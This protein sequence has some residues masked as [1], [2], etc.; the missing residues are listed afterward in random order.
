PLGAPRPVQPGPPEQPSQAPAAQSADAPQEAPP[1]A[2]EKTVRVTAEGYNRD[3]ALKQALRRA[4]EQGA[5]VQLTAHAQTE[6]Y[7][8]VRDTVYS[9]AAGLI[10]EYRVLKEEE[11]ARGN[12]EVTID[13]VVRP[14]VVAAAWGEIQMLLDQVGRPK[15]MVW[16]DETID[17]ELQSQSVVETSI[18]ELLT[19][20][21]FDIVARQGIE[22][23]RRRELAA[24]RAQRDPKNSGQAE[25]DAEKLARLAKDAGAHI[26]IRGTAN[27]NRAGVSTHYGI[28]A[29]YYN[30][31]AQ[32]K[33]YYTDTARVLASETSPSQRAGARSQQEYSPQAARA[34]LKLATLPGSPDDH[35]PTLATKL[36]DAVL[37]QWS[38]Q[39]SAGGDVELEVEG[40]DFRGFVDLKRALTE[41]E[42]V[43]SVD[44]DFTRGAGRYRIKTLMSAHTLAELLAEAPFTRPLEITDLKPNRI[45]ARPAGGAE[46]RPA[47]ESR[48]ASALRA[49]N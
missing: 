47:T 43:R 13:A 8:L 28:A 19:R 12:W 26:L 33:V 21:G 41:L 18:E 49:E 11:V 3:D 27:A 29:A 39:I 10:R 35:R 2:T 7:V 20:T 42:R 44:G 32:A 31:D 46:T 1:D 24:A 22:D 36:L 4:I 48:P 17:G 14:D 34:A 16:I 6:D 38:I 37:E 25:A 5:G 9:R 23:I 45:Q 30:C 40:L 15:I